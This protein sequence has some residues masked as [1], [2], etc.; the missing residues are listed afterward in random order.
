MINLLPNGCL[1][2][3]T[4]L[5]ALPPV[6]VPLEDAGYGGSGGGSPGD[7]LSGNP[8]DITYKRIGPQTDICVPYLSL[9]HF[10]ALC[11]TFLEMQ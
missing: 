6:S 8:S 5:A 3:Y 2:S 10:V 4:G 7:R 9:F 11:N 1:L